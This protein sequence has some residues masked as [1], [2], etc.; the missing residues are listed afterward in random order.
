MRC[1]HGRHHPLALDSR[2]RQVCSI[3]TC[4]SSSVRRNWLGTSQQVCRSFSGLLIPSFPTIVRLLELNCCAIHLTA[5]G[6]GSAFAVPVAAVVGLDLVMQGGE[7][8]VPL[9]D[10]PSGVAH[11]S[12]SCP[13]VFI[14]IASDLEGQLNKNQKFHRGVS[15]S[16]QTDGCHIHRRWSDLLHG[17][18][19]AAE[20]TKA[21]YCLLPDQRKKNTRVY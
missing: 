13:V 10:G 11:P 6:G 9:A 3:Q 20:S 5:A 21:V 19:D 2:S 12:D 18:R 8:V 17:T 1:H 4:R 7:V 14:E 16:H 15:N